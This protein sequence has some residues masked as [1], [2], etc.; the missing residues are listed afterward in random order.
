MFNQV[1]D[2][3]YQIVANTRITRVDGVTQSEQRWR[4][5]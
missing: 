4:E 1:E 5:L 2:G 3:Y